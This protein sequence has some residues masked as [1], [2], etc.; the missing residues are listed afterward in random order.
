MSSRFSVEVE[1]VEC[2]RYNVGGRNT[3][4]SMDTKQGEDESISKRQTQYTH[5]RDD[6]NDDKAT[7]DYVDRRL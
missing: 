3:I 1:I 7:R 6:D 4:F 5:G 2:R